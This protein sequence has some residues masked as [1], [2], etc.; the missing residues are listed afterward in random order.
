MVLRTSEHLD[1][2][3]SISSLAV[4]AGLFILLLVIVS[5]V[6]GADG[7]DHAAADGHHVEAPDGSG[8][9]QVC[10]VNL[11]D[12]LYTRLFSFYFHTLRIP[13]FVHSGSGS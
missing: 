7:Q 10:D 9:P 13:I 3:Y 12:A 8:Q 2:Y 5:T 11:N 6:F 4:S 1:N